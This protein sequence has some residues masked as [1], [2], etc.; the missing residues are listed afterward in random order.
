MWKK[1]EPVVEEKKTIKPRKR[2]RGVVLGAAALST[3]LSGV[4]FALPSTHDKLWHKE[5]SRNEERAKLILPFVAIA[6]TA[7][8]M[9]MMMD[10]TSS[11]SRARTMLAAAEF[12]A[13]S[14]IVKSTAMDAVKPEMRKF[15]V[16]ANTT[17]AST[18]VLASII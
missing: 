9:A 2:I 1:K 18:L 16:I 15:A 8:S 7:Q 13:G 11:P 6:I 5:S 10:A 12:G 4:S 17:F 3:L 14:V